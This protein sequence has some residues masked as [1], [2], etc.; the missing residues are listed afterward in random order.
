M[1]MPLWNRNILA[2][3]LV[4]EDTRKCHASRHK[5]RPEHPDFSECRRFPGGY[6][7]AASYCVIWITNRAENCSKIRAAMPV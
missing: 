2:V 7:Q 5:N 3:K 6:E 1:K 4:R